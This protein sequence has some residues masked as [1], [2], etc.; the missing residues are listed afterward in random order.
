MIWCG[1]TEVHTIPRTVHDTL[2]TFEEGL[3]SNSP[4]ISNSMI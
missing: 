2:E 4:D 3:R 1:S